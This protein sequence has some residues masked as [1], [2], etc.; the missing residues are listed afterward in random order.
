M[1]NKKWLSI[2]VAFVVSIALWFYIVTVENPVKETT[3]S[4]I[5][6]SFVGLDEAHDL[7]IVDNNAL[8]G[9][10]ITFSGRISDLNKLQQ[11][12]SDIMLQIDISRL[13]QP[14]QRSYEINI[15]DLVL[16]SSVSKQDFEIISAYPEVVNYSLET[17]SRKTVEV[18]IENNVSA[19]EGFTTGTLVQDISEVLVEGPEAVVSNI[20]IAKAK[21][22]RE[23]PANQSID[24]TLDLMLFDAEGNQIKSPAVTCSSPTV[25]VNLPVVMIKTVP[26]VVTIKDGGGATIDDVEY[27]LRTEEITISGEPA[28]IESISD[29]KLQAIEL[30]DVN[31]NNDV[32]VKQVIMPEN[33]TNVS[34]IKEVEVSITIKNKAIRIFNI[35]SISFQ[36][37]GLPADLDVKYN[38]TVLPVTVRANADIID[39]ITEDNIRVIVDFEGMS[40]APNNNV[41]VPILVSSILI[42]GVDGNAGAI[43]TGYSVN[44]DIF[45]IS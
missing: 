14:Q 32:V 7:I 2:L 5:P 16:P 42:D 20:H 12:E 37:K 3:I 23:E 45:S 21:L 10:E 15:K 6:V 44:L 29:V 4:D 41:N 27:K 35:S 22:E 31:S 30:E 19:A 17:V 28:V 36:K 24:A 18:K 25:T 39:Q 38:T 40:T 26:L 34:G 13:T 8:N 43:D 33:C 9:V 11:A 1:K